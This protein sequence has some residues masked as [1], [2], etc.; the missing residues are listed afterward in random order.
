MAAKP[1]VLSSEWSPPLPGFQPRRPMIVAPINQDPVA[2]VLLD[3]AAAGDR[4]VLREVRALLTRPSLLDDFGDLAGYAL[5]ALV[6]MAAGDNLAIAIGVRKKYEEIFGRLLADAGPEP[7]FAEELAAT[8]AAHAAPAV[9][10][11]ELEANRQVLGSPTAQAFEKH[12]SRA[13]QRLSSA[14][15]GCAM[16]RRLKR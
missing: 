2:Q 3:R 7:S 5:D 15:K 11:I 8:R 1:A 13:E 9:Y 10:F 16:L 6:F 4:T 14:M 12:L